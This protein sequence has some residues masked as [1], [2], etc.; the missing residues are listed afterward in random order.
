MLALGVSVGY[1]LPAQTPPQ[2]VA[3]AGQVISRVVIVPLAPLEKSNQPL[4]EAPVRVLNSTHSV[5]QP[6]VVQA[7]VQLKA[8][9]RCDEFRRR[10][11][12]RVLRVQPFIASAEI[13]VYADDDGKVYLVVTTRDE[14]TFIFAT[15]LSGRSPYV[16]AL[17]VGDA[18]LQGR[19]VSF[20]ANWTHT[21]TR[22]GFG[23]AFTDYS[24]MNQPMVAQLAASRGDVG[25]SS[26]AG[27]LSHPFYSDAQH[28][29]W[30][31]AGMDA[32]LLYG[33]QQ[34]DT[35]PFDVAERREFAAA[36]GALRVGRPGGPVF[37]IGA[38]ASTEYDATGF[39][40]TGYD[41]TVPYD[42][43]FVRY[44]PRRSVR[45][46]LIGQL[47]AIRY[48]RGVRL[49]TLNGVQDLKLGAE[50]SGILG[51]GF[52]GIDGS[53]GD[54]FG[55][56]L[57][58]LGLGGARTYS[59]LQ[60]IMEARRGD[61]NGEWSDAIGSARLILYQRIGD[62]Q[63]LVADAEFG[64][65]WLTTRPF[66]LDIGQPEGGVRGFGS[67]HVAGG[68]RAALKLEERW[69]IGSLGKEADLGLAAFVDA[70]RTWAGDVPYGVSSPLKVG[71]GAGFLL[72]TPTGSRRTY[73][74]DIAIPV[75]ADQ[76]ARW[77]LRVTVINIAE[78]GARREPLDVTGGREL[79]TTATTFTFPR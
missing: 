62:T 57:F 78:L 49:G 41:S 66:E 16:T 54:T 55:M 48:R 72:A 15:R 75:T 9:D 4:Y 64:G 3:C 33:F 42:S 6:A 70:G 44:A 38:G 10:E 35:T 63:T 67:S 31:V 12:E 39:P 40:A 13:A 21:D 69:F 26:F 29:A 47:R 68:Q 36:G 28:G 58:F 30:R 74:A 1:P 11:S 17:T 71:V 76:Y 59:Y 43:L 25:V 61:V 60:A 27:E 52:S 50:L 20:A 56:G 73:R 22:E 24:F 14:F 19:G 2:R 5:T 18:D 79:I 8:G 34:A 7:F 65:G 32:N 51:H 23:A 37:L 46:N 53:S 77:E 45:V